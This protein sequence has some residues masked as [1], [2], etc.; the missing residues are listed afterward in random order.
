MPVSSAYRVAAWVGRPLGWVGIVFCLTFAAGS[1]SI[2][3][4]HRGLKAWD[5]LDTETRLSFG[6][7]A[8]T[9]A[10]QA[11]LLLGGKAVGLIVK[12][13]G[14]GPLPDTAG[15]ILS[16]VTLALSIYLL[17]KS[18]WVRRTVRFGQRP[19]RADGAVDGTEPVKPPIAVVQRHPLYR[20]RSQ[21]TNAPRG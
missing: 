15:S 3:T 9:N 19:T 14:L 21:P 8:A 20:W 10:P 2:A 18:A 1:F 12:S 4:T 7:Y 17:P 16:S 6:E 11:A 13:L 5:R